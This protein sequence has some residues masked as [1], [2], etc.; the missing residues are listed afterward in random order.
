MP[1]TLE[2]VR[3]TFKEKGSSES[4]NS[5]RAFVLSDRTMPSCVLLDTRPAMD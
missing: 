3:H 5:P 4:W 1:S 2:S